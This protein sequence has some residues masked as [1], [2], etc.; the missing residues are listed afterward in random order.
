MT[1][2][3][4]IGLYHGFQSIVR[5]ANRISHADNPFRHVAHAGL[6]LRGILEVRVRRQRIASDYP[7]P[8]VG[9]DSL[10]S[11]ENGIAVD[12][13]DRRPRVMWF[14]PNQLA[15]VASRQASTKST[16]RSARVKSYLPQC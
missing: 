3:V 4:A 13:K 10:A 16:D 1:G 2:I 5:S 8:H 15:D 11:T 7:I 9:L 6:G 12:G 14:C